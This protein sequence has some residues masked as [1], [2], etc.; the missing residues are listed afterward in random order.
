MSGTLAAVPI[1]RHG[2]RVAAAPTKGRIGH[3]TR[4]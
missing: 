3:L 1:P 2:A 4:T